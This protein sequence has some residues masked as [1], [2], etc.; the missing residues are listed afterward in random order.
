M[1]DVVPCDVVSRQNSIMVNIS[2]TF[3]ACDKILQNNASLMYESETQ[4]SKQLGIRMQD[5]S[6]SVMS[7]IPLPLQQTLINATV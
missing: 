6:L 5:A 7:I 2:D 1:F 3:L 4:E